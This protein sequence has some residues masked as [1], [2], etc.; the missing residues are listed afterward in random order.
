LEVISLS[1]K[2]KDTIKKYLRWYSYPLIYFLVTGIVC[3]YAWYTRP[4]P[5]RTGI[6]VA[7][8][9]ISVIPTLIW[10]GATTLWILASL[11]LIG[12]SFWLQKRFHQLSIWNKIER[13]SQGKKNLEELS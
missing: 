8:K 2:I 4:I 9:T 6:K 11:L 5:H 1:V 12:I 13:F 10:A 3:L 7:F